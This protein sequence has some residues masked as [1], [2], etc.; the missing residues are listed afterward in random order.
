MLLVGAVRHQADA[1]LI[2]AE[3]PDQEV[4]A[5]PAGRDHPLAPE[6]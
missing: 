1:I 2:D 6:R 3:G 4:P 5:F